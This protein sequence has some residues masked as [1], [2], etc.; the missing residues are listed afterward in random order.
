MNNHAQF[1]KFIREKDAIP[2]SL[3]LSRQ[4]LESRKS[5]ETHGQAAKKKA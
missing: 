2:V 5:I 3:G 1:I 4:V